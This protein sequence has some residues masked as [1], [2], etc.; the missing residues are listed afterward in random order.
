M[1]ELKNDIWKIKWYFEDFL[2]KRPK[3]DMGNKNLK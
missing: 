1:E 2:I 3:D